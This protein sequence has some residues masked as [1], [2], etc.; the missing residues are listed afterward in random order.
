[1]Q[2]GA[3]PLSLPS[4]V[5]S[6]PIDIA[7]NV[8]LPQH[9][10]I[11]GVTILL[12]VGQYLFFTRTMLGRMMQATA[13]D[14]DAARL[15]GIPVTRCI[16]WTFV[17]SGRMAG[18]AGLLLS[19]VFFV[20]TDMGGMVLLKAFVASIVGGFGSIPGAIVGAIVLGLLEIFGAAYI[21][22]KWKD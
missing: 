14:P 9:L 12:L 15:M 20:T 3:L 10:F 18:I 5:G 4:L 6:S 19:P 21:D 17:I 11:I 16:I 8:I 7:G 13:Q 2:W 1:L 22:S